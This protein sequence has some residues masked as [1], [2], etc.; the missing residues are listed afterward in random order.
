MAR[1]KNRISQITYN[2]ATQCFDAAVTLILG[3]EAYTYPVSLPAPLDS[4]YEDVTKA[5]LAR[6]KRMHESANPGFRSRKPAED[7]LAM[8]I[9]IPPSVREATVGLWDRLLNDGK[10][11]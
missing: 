8:P 2:P 9:I 11:A 1:Q 5:V 7:A 10:A 4:A 3:D 6:A